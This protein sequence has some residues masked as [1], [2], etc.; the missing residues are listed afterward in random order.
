MLLLGMVEARSVNECEK[1][2]TANM[3]N[4]PITSNQRKPKPPNPRIIIY[5]I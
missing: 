1:H 5:L 4:V 2:T 3:P